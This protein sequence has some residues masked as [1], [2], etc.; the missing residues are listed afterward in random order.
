M[1][2]YTFSRFRNMCASWK[3]PHLPNKL[4]FEAKGVIMMVSVQHDVACLYFSTLYV[5]N[6]TL[7]QKKNS[8]EIQ[9]NFAFGLVGS[10]WCCVFQ[11]KAHRIFQEAAQCLRYMALSPCISF[12][13]VKRGFY[14]LS[15][16]LSL[17]STD[18]LYS[19]YDQCSANVQWNRERES[20]VLHMTTYGK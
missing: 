19:T 17:L 5:K 4:Y 7:F 2:I 3:R 1:N 12:A 15:Y 18:V 8:N 11:P 13:T 20:T 6:L 14:K 16:W 10:F 9:N